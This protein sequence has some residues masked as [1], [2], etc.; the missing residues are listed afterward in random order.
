MIYTV[1]VV[2]KS[3]VPVC[4]NHESYEYTAVVMVYESLF[5]LLVVVLV[6]WLSISLGYVMR[7]IN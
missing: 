4:V 1:R 2:L 6:I 3:E 5:L 7:I